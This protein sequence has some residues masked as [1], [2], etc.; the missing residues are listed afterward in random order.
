MNPWLALTGFWTTGPRW[1]AYLFNFKSSSEVLKLWH[2]LSTLSFRHNRDLTVLWFL[3]LHSSVSIFLT[4]EKQ[5]S[6]SALLAGRASSALTRVSLESVRV[7][8]PISLISCKAAQN[9]PTLQVFLWKVY[10]LCRLFE[11]QL[12]WLNSI[13]WAYLW[14]EVAVALWWEEQWCWVSPYTY[15]FHLGLKL[16][17]RRVAWTWK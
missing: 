4:I 15:T 14:I 16:T 10:L 5:H 3:W 9:A 11:S 2:L 13:H 7:A 6:L 8:D 17:D 12:L 1:T